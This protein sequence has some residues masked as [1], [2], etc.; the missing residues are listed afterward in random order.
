MSYIKLIQDESFSLREFVPKVKTL[1]LTEEEERN[2]PLDGSFI[3]GSL[4]AE[5]SKINWGHGGAHNHPRDAYI[6]INV[7]DV[8]KFPNLF[9]PK[10]ANKGLRNADNDPIDI[11]WDDGNVMTGILEGTQNVNGE[12]YPNKIGSYRDKKILGDYLRERMGLEQGVFVTETD[13]INYGRDNIRIKK[14]GDSTYQFD[15]SK[16]STARP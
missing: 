15:F 2:Q 12:R 4:Y 1:S 6:P 14:I 16:P 3:S 5:K 7:P 11:I 9:P 13:F 8:K 10:T